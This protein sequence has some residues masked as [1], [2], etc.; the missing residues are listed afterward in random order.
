MKSKSFSKKRGIVFNECLTVLDRQEC[1]VEFNDFNIGKIMA[2][3]PGGILSYGHN[4]EIIVKTSDNNKTKV[5]V[6]SSSMGIQVIDW[7]TNSSNEEDFITELT[8]ALK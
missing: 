6:T 8:N 3:K 5:S 7:G 1:N 2:S 4:L